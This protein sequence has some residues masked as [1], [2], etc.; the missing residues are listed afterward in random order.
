MAAALPPE[1]DSI[2]AKSDEALHFLASHPDL[3]HPD[4][5]AAAQRELQRRGVVVRVPAPKTPAFPEV[6]AYS[7]SRSFPWVALG[8]GA[9]VLLVGVVVY[10]SSV[11]R[12][13]G[14]TT[15]PATLHHQAAQPGDPLPNL[16]SLT[17]AFVRRTPASLPA[18]ERAND[19]A[20]HN[21]Q[22]LAQRYWAAETQTD[23]LL[24]R[25]TERTSIDPTLPGK[26][27]MTSE[28]WSSL[29]RVL[30]YDL[31]LQPEML[32]RAYRMAE[33]AELRLQELN[34]LSFNLQQG[35]SLVTTYL[36]NH[37]ERAYA[38]RAQ[39][40]GE[41]TT[42]PYP[43]LALQVKPDVVISPELPLHLPLSP[44]VYV[45]HGQVL[46]SNRAGGT[47]PRAVQALQPGDV[48]SV[49]V[50]RPA[51]ARRLYGPQAEDGAV[52]VFTSADHR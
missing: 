33:A 42:E 47:P 48:D 29:L 23:W 1:T 43:V 25:V 49:A 34:T 8:A 44:P 19:K 13:E 38:L 16:D 22:Q 24:H 17:Q 7:P 9:V 11:R 51:V 10:L 36:R 15:L 30:R 18:A 5:V 31:Q 39:V 32:T 50:L 4:I 37:Y 21:Y 28:Q 3:Y 12:P 35:D 52:L 6:P 45:L 41:Q 40:L 26:I 14:I 46:P 27:K 20:L 2:A